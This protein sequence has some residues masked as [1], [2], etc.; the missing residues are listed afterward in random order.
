MQRRSYFTFILAA[1]FIA[2][3]FVAVNAQSGSFSGKVTIKKQD[4]TIVPAAG[5]T[6]IAYR[7]DAEKGSIT[8]VKTN[9]KGDF[10]FI[11]VNP[12][13]KFALLI[14][15]PGIAPAIQ[16]GFQTGVENFAIEVS[17]GNGATFTEE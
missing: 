17:E 3:G 15:G 6:I 10:T 4:G 2:A 9:D 8:P 12:S 5:I 1:V 13:H 7:V 11:G 14:S 16:Q